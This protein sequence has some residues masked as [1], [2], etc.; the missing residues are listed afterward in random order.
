M[1]LF[2]LF[3]RVISTQLSADA[4]EKI[5]KLV[6]SF[7]DVAASFNLMVHSQL[8]LTSMTLFEVYHLDILEHLHRY[9]E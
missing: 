3:Q 5:L 2:S 6:L 1:A 7:N 8:M 4:K 9:F